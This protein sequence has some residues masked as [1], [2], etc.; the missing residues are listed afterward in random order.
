MT[1]RA[2]ESEIGQTRSVIGSLGWVARQCR[3]DL[4]YE[5]SRGQSTVSRATIQ[6]LKLTNEAVEKCREGS[7]IGLVLEAG[8]VDWDTAVLVTIIDASFAQ[9]EETN[10]KEDKRSIIDRRSRD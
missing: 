8:S 5:V 2:T 4:S 10:E 7:S 1:E 3:G 6:D 9:E